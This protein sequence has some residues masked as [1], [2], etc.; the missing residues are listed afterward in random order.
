MANT[1][2]LTKK[3]TST[4]LVTWSV[5]FFDRLLT[6]KPESISVVWRKLKT[7]LRNLGMPNIRMEYEQEMRLYK[8]MGMDAEGVWQSTY[9]G[10]DRV[11]SKMHSMMLEGI[12]QS[13]AMM[14]EETLD[15]AES[16]Y[17]MLDSVLSAQLMCSP[18]P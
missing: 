10:M 16:F 15:I 1:Y 14:P 18:A 2:R 6:S 5:S 7:D 17:A 12:N 9:S 11:Y 13:T 3:N 4:P 8:H